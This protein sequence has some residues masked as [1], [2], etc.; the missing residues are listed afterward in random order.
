MNS[1]DDHHERIHGLT[2]GLIK[3]PAEADRLYGRPDTT[4]GTLYAR[5]TSLR[6]ALDRA[7]D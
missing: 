4:Y 7:A 5:A 2:H 1:M 6:K 3:G